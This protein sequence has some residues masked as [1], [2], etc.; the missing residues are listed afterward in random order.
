[1]GSW[2]LSLLAA[3]AIIAAIFKLRTV[4]QRPAGCPPGPPTLP[5]IGNL[6]Q[7]PKKNAHV[8]FKKWAEEY[9]PVYSLVL[10]TT[11]MIVLSSD[12]AIKDLLD[13]RS[14]IYSSRPDMYIGSLAGAGLRLVLMVGVSRMPHCAPGRTS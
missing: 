6:H 7:L 10:G 3:T 12:V 1:M 11:V 5:I 8:Q 4:G 2:L 13:K 14:G 9:G